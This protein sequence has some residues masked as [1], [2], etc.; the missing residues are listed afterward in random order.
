MISIGE[1]MSKE[2]VLELSIMRSYNPILQTPGIFIADDL[3][4][5][6]WLATVRP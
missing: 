6:T 1:G 5:Y 3:S 4:F 2:D